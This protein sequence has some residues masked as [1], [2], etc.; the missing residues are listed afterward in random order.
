MLNKD[1]KAI[2]KKYECKIPEKRRK[3]W[4]VQM[5]LWETFDAICKKYN[6]RYFFFWGALLGAVRH[7][8]FIPW[9]DD[10]DVVMPRKDYDKFAKVALP[11][12]KTP[13]FLLSKDTIDDAGLYLFIRLVD[14]STT[15]ISNGFSASSVAH[16]GIALDIVPL[17]G[18][19]SSKY[20]RVRQFVRE[21][22]YHVILDRSLHNPKTLS[23]KGKVAWTLSKIYCSVKG[24][25]KS[26]EQFE[27]VRGRVKW[28]ESDKV[29][30][31]AHHNVFFRDDFE[32]V[33]YFPFEGKMAPVP[34]GYEH[35]LTELYG[36]YM[37]IP[38]KKSR[39]ITE[40]EARGFIID[41]LVPYAD[42]FEL[43]QKERAR[44]MKD[45]KEYKKR[46]FE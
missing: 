44:V 31:G 4:D 29:V 3:V 30:E 45:Q 26:I 43:L 14:E 22:F 34:I 32:D 12:I 35:I 18:I 38:D 9:D 24:R 10:I 16:Q 17:D 7:Q 1:I 20:A 36:D 33:V 15:C 2:E 41:P 28:D 13:Y 25:K 40:H 37:Q 27:A 46:Y 39:V 42:Y 6:L 19:P 8:G 23:I 5:C 11:E 21:E